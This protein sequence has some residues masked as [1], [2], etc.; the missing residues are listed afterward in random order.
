[1]PGGPLGGVN[2]MLGTGTGLAI[3]SRSS[4]PSSLAITGGSTKFPAS[5]FSAPQAT[6]AR[7]ATLPN[8]RYVE[9]FRRIPLPDIVSLLCGR[10]IGTNLPATGRHKRFREPVA[11]G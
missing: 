2:K 4:K 9:D 8:H 6:A 3:I 7:R 10:A 11:H 1:M 5:A